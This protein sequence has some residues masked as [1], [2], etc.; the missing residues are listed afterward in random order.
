LQKNFG[1]KD[2]CGYLNQRYYIES[3]IA[4][5]T[6][7]YQVQRDGIKLYN[8][9]N[10]KDCALLKKQNKNYDDLYEIP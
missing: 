8:E 1:Q 4:E 7:A 5:L 2:F 10:D 6:H 9:K 3:W